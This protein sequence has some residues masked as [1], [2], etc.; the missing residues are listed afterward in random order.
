MA[1]RDAVR[2]CGPAAMGRACRPWPRSTHDGVPPVRRAPRRDHLGHR[3]SEVE[4]RLPI[5]LGRRSLLL[6]LRRGGRV[7]ASLDV[8]LVA[9]LRDVQRD[10]R[11][12]DHDRR[13]DTDAVFAVAVREAIWLPP[14]GLYT[15]GGTLDLP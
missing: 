1:A 8:R 15:P 5:H 12:R 14:G 2:T 4:D 10:R 6:V 3:S 11:R 9:L 7:G 13:G